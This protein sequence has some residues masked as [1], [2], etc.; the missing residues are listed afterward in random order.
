M[1]LFECGGQGWII[2]RGGNGINA[3]ASEQIDESKN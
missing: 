1:A 3:E 2:A